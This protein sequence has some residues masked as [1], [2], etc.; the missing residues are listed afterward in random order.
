MRRG[1]IITLICFSMFLSTSGGAVV[2]KTAAGKDPQVVETYFKVVNFILSGSFDE[3]DQLIGNIQ[4]AKELTVNGKRRLEVLYDRLL[5]ID[6]DLIDIWCRNAPDSPHAFIV[7][8]KQQLRNRQNNSSLQQAY[9]DLETAHKLAPGN[10]AG[11]AELVRYCTLTG[12]P[13]GE[14]EDWYTKAI[15]ADPFWLA[16]YDNKLHFLSPEH[17]GSEA[18]MTDFAINCAQNSPPGSSVYST[19]FNYFK[20]LNTHHYPP[21]PPQTYALKLPAKAR[22]AFLSTI[23][24]FKADFAHS[25][26]PLLYEAQFKFLAGE[27]LPAEFILNNIVEI[28]P[29]NT[30]ALK[31]LIIVEMNGDKWEKAKKSIT[32]LLKLE[33][34]ST[35][36]ITNMAA[37]NMLL[38]NNPKETKKLYEKAIRLEQ[39]EELKKLYKL[40]LTNLLMYKGS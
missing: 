22:E 31:A 36:A 11:A 14:M 1:L 27:R 5:E 10:P 40:D 30:E 29:E 25:S 17:H 2:Q 6:P 18:L 37:L 16:A 13:P 19:I 38:L 24:H 8:G 39:S 7:R 28:E 15:E 9:T 12:C 4:G 33:P 34:E 23:N 20:I 35:F 26:I 32:A 3:L 21:Y